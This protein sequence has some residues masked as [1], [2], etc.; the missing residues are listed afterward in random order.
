MLIRERAVAVIIEVVVV[1]DIE[2]SSGI[3]IP[4]KQKLPTHVSTQCVVVGP[5]ANI[6]ESSELIGRSH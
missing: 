2:R 5:Q 4:T 1:S 6:R 3:R